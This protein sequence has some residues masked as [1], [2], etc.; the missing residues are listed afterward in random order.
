MTRSSYQNLFASW[1]TSHNASLAF[2]LTFV[3]LWAG[4][5]WAFHRAGIFWKV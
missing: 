2:A 3:L 4:A 1:L 5:M